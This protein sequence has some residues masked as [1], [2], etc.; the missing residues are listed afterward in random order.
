MGLD[1]MMA[2]YAHE[3]GG[4]PAPD[5]SWRLFLAAVSRTPRYQARAQLSTFDAVAG[6]IGGAFSEKGASRA[7]AA[8]R[9]LTRQAYPVKDRQAEFQPNMFAPGGQG[10]VDA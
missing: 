5:S 2:D 8:R 4:F 7:A 6:A 10:A 1:D 3:F 9:R